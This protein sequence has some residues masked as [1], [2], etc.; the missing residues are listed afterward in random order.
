MKLDLRSAGLHQ[1]PV[2][3]TGLLD[4]EVLL[5]SNPVRSRDRGLHNR[6]GGSSVHTNSVKTNTLWNLP[7]EFSCLRGLVHLEASNVNL[8]ALPT[9]LGS[10]SCLQYLDVSVNLISWLPE[11]ILTLGKL[12]TLNVA[13]NSLVNLPTGKSVNYFNELPDR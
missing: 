3:L 11:E 4:L 6:G 8:T 7:T 9:G 12:E 10:L 1:F 5:L 2:G 13:E